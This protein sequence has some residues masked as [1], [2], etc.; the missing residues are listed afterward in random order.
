M[1][2][3]CSWFAIISLIGTSSYSGHRRSLSLLFVVARFNWYHLRTLLILLVV[4]G[5]LFARISY[6]KRMG[7]NHRQSVARLVPAIAVSERTTGD[8]V[9]GS[10]RFLALGESTLGTKHFPIA[11]EP[12]VKVT[13]LENR[14]GNARV[15][16]RAVCL[17]AE[18]RPSFI[19]SW[20]TG[21]T[22]H[23]FARGHL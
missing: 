13:V 6:L 1:R 15:I 8:E 7:H 4:A 17:L 9:E 23:Y 14:I 19:R 5:I 2:A 12:T 20:R 11:D 18:V 22:G 16:H 21:T 3:G 10:I